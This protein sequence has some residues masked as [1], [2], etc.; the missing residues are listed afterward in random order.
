MKNIK[1]DIYSNDFEDFS[2]FLIISSKEL[3]FINNLIMHLE[4]HFR[5][6]QSSIKLGFTISERWDNDV[7]M[8]LKFNITIQGKQELN[9]K[10]IADFFNIWDSFI[11]P[12]CKSG[13]PLT[14]LKYFLNR[15]GSP[16]TTLKYFLNKLTN[17]KITFENRKGIYEKWFNNFF[18]QYPEKKL[19]SKKEIKNYCQNIDVENLNPVAF[20]YNNAYFPLLYSNNSFGRETSLEY[21]FEKDIENISNFLQEIQDY[22]FY[23]NEKNQ[24]N[25]DYQAKLEII[26]SDNKRFYRLNDNTK[27]LGSILCLKLENKNMSEIF[28]CQLSSVFFSFKESEK[29]EM[30]VSSDL[31]DFDKLPLKIRYRI[32]NVRMLHG[33]KGGI[34]VKSLEQYMIEKAKEEN[35]II[36]NLFVSENNNINLKVRL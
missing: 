21:L 33:K 20:F 13:S 26:Y 5:H 1:T 25:S 6:N 10:N 11:I 34:K 14:T 31:N 23:N 24:I 29:K 8:P 30:I 4:K 32:M 28:Y 9:N 15:S 35:I 2:T 16:L 17:E 12:G 3:S 19:I 7:D 18:D 22:I 27:H 36:E